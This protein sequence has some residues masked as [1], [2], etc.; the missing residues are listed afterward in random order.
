[1]LAGAASAED[2]FARF[3]E[4]RIRDKIV[5][6][7]ITDRVHWVSITETTQFSSVRIWAGNE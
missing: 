3:S 1:M 4:K 6:K 5:G 2:K 7:E